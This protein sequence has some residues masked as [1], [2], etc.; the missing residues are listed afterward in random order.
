MAFGA[1]RSR[2]SQKEE[3]G[4]A[5]DVMEE[6]ACRPALPVRVLS[7]KNFL[8]ETLVLC[9]KSFPA[10]GA[11]LWFRLPVTGLSTVALAKWN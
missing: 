1:G 11:Q 8:D 3:I 7:E 9:N 10:K 2:K 4:L 6:P 5:A